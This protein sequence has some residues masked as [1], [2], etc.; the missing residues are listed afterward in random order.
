MHICAAWLLT[1]ALNAA[2]VPK[3]VDSYER[4]VHLDP[5]F[6]LAWARLSRIDANLYF[7]HE[8]ATPARRDAAKRAL[9]NAQKLAPN[10]PETLLALGYYQYWVL[11]DYGAAK[12]TLQRASEMLP[13]SS[14]APYALG[15]LA[16][17]EGH[18]DEG[19]SYFDRALSLDPRNVELLTNAA[20]TYLALRQ[21]PAAL[22]L[23]DRVLDITPNDLGCYGKQ[24]PAFIRPRVTCK[25]PPG[26]CQQIN[27]QTSA[28]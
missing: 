9:E 8:D 18:W 21:F 16:R 20:N 26:C 14:E 4:A 10:S 15:R 5:K 28:Y 24:R 22:K 19:V 23:Y 27:W 12:T 11:L 1:H 6:A 13:G 25:K 17:R 3:I 7:T 2:E